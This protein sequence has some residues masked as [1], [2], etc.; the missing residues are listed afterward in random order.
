MTNERQTIDLAPVPGGY[1]LTVITTKFF[2]EAELKR[3]IAEVC[4][5]EIDERV[6][7][8]RRA[9]RRTAKKTRRAS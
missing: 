6:R 3:D 1:L 4:A 8:H 5:D 7:A 9:H 2:T